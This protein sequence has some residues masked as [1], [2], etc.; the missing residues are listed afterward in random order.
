M[1][2]EMKRRAGQCRSSRVGGWCDC[3]RQ[4]GVG[5]KKGEEVEVEEEGRREGSAMARARMDCYTKKPGSRPAPLTAYQ[6]PIE[7]RHA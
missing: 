5:G 6:N 3:V 4:G 7:I 1:V 2:A